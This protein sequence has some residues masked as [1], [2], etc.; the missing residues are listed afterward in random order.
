MHCA[1]LAQVTLLTPLALVT[2]VVIS[3]DADVDVDELSD[4]PPPQDTNIAADPR[5]K[6]KIRPVLVHTS[7][8]TVLHASLNISIA[9]NFTCIPQALFSK[10]IWNLAFRGGK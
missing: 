3:V 2:K 8:R 5:H 9:F 7:E 4:P 10:L 1:F 6:L